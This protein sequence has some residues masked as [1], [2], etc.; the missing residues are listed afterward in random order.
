MM[1]DVREWVR[2][3][4][5][6]A[7][8]LH[9]VLTNSRCTTPLVAPLQQVALQARDVVEV[10][11]PSGSAKSELLLQAAVTCLLPERL[12]GGWE[13]G[14]LWY[15]LDGHFDILRLV[16]L[17]QARIHQ[18]KA[19]SLGGLIEDGDNIMNACLERFLLTRCYNSFD[20][21]AA[22]QT[23]R[24]QVKEAQRQGRSMRL[25]IIDSIG[26]F[27]WLDRAAS[28]VAGASIESSR[29]SIQAV[30][31]AVVRELHQLSNMHGL[32]VL[33]SKCSIFSPQ[34][35]DARKDTRRAGLQH[36]EY[37]PAEWQEFVTH[38]LLLQGPMSGEAEVVFISE[39]QMPAL[40]GV[41]RFTIENTGLKLVI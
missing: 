17:L 28:L 32:L 5:S 7:C 40:S 29:P 18:G 35:S 8:M 31:R 6:V 20:F 36:R 25:L 2:G 27:Y 12:Y 9:R 22:L 13:G 39:W 10:A 34:S 26:A 3:H 38:R 1:M 19:L 11:G 23:T 24:N 33:A 41:D 30:T 21:I 14:V 15:D 16:C 4:E 37:M